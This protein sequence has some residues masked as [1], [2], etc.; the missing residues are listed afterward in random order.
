[1]GVVAIEITGIPRNDNLYSYSVQEDATRLDPNSFEGGFGQLAFS[2]NDWSDSFRLSNTSVTLSDGS[3]GKFQGIVR[4][5]DSTDGVI[6][7]TADGA[8]SLFNA[9]RTVQPFQGTLE[10]YMQYLVGLVGITNNLVV[11]SSIRTTPVIAPGYVGNVWDN[12]KQFFAVNQWEIALVFNRVVV[13]PIR[14][15]Y[16]YHDNVITET[17]TRNNQVTAE[18]IEIYWYNHVWGSQTQ[19]Y[20]VPSASGGLS[21]PIVVNA[22][23]TI[24]Q[25]FSIDGSLLSINQPVVQ[26]FVANTSYAGTNGVY[27]V[28]GND[29]LPVTAAQWT[30]EGGRL[31]V[32]ITEDPS[33]IEV[34]VTG[35][36]TAA[37]SPFRIAMTAGT[38]SYYD[39]LR[40]TGTGI[41]W[42]KE[43]LT[44]HTGAAPSATGEVVGATVDNKYVR[45]LADAYTAGLHTAKAFSGP[46]ITLSGSAPSLNRPADDDAYVTSTIG[47]FNT[48]HTG[49]TIGQFNI[50][51]TGWSIQQ[52]NDFW[53]ARTADNFDNQ[54]FGQGVGSQ[55]V[56][57]DLIYRVVST[58]TDPAVVQYTAVTDTIIDV[59]NYFWSGKTIG[60]FNTRYAGYRIQDFNASPIRTTL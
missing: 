49:D 10:A 50:E 17:V 55:I 22:N 59:F 9:W 60:D 54:L 26:D 48:Y 2:T 57:K 21:N 53:R 6:N 42:N 43:L 52:F 39:S 20:P 8:L 4:D 11:D 41:T 37:L 44:L 15:I 46:T 32:R 24:V 18:Q 25:Q 13:R 51:Y 29:G 33:I 12:L 14:K 56:T 36:R 35:A 23:E 1:M 38:S 58:T 27:A 45:T 7:I 16:A 47:Q 30:A 28:A 31:S 3:R 19:V 34:T 5:T 40:I